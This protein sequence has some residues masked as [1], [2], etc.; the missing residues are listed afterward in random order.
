MVSSNDLLLNVGKCSILTCP[1]VCLCGATRLIRLC[2]VIP[3]P[4]SMGV[5]DGKDT[6]S[7][8]TENTAAILAEVCYNVWFIVFSGFP[9]KGTI[10]HVH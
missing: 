5:G 3:A 8:G 1:L 7:R 10:I 4:V 9:L 2:R 6:H